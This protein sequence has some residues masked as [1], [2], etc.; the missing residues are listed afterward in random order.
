MPS[1]PDLIVLHEHPEWQK[2]LFA[3]LGAPAE[4]KRHLVLPGGHGIIYERRNQVIREILD[5]F[6]RYLGPVR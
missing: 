3:A 4:Q 5:W 2:P 6:D 1:N